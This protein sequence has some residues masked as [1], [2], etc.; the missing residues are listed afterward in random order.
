MILRLLTA[1]DRKAV[2]RVLAPRRASSRAVAAQVAR[3]VADVRRRGDRAVVA[4][5]RAL[6]GL[7]ASIEVTRDEIE[8][9]W[10]ATPAP[11]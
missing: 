9:G 10:R 4:H 3:I 5:A 1:D 6:D 11:V 2:D 8:A 7:A